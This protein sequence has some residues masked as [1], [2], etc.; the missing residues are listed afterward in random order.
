MISFEPNHN[1]VL[2]F[3]VCRRSFMFESLIPTYGRS[4]S[5]ADPQAQNIHPISS[6]FKPDELFGELEAEDL[7]WT[8]ASGFVTETQ[9]FYH[10]LDD[11]TF[12][13]CQVIHSATG[14]VYSLTRPPRVYWA[15]NSLFTWYTNII[16]ECGIQLS[17][18]HARS[19][20]RRPRR[21]PGV[22]SRHPT[23]YPP[24][25]VKTSA[26]AKQTSFPS[27]IAQLAAILPKPRAT[28]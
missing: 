11:G 12:L 19:T 27:L 7:H 21:R 20:I 2:N 15:H 22:R 6:A 4:G 10:I 9:T 8:C 24:L 18:L 3:W 14:L 23:S 5:T 25:R 16:L 13:T 17:N 28:R 26:L 1:H